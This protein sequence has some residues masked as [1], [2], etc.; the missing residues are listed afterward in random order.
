MR[1]QLR[2]TEGVVTLEVIASEALLART[3]GMGE[4]GA[5]QL[6]RFA[7]ANRSSNVTLRVIPFAAGGHR[8]MSGSFTLLDFPPVA[9]NT[10]AY[11]EGALH[12]ELTD[13]QL[14][15][16]DLTVTWDGLDAQALDLSGTSELIRTLT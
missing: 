16:T 9:S 5:E 12:G 13:D 1:R 2:V 10:V 14:A 7:Q 8:S 15:V 11:R 4:V 6:G 3:A